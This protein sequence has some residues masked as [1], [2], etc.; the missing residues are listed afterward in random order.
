[1]EIWGLSVSPDLDTLTY[2][3]AG[4]LDVARGWGLAGE[5]FRCLEAMVDLGGE[6]W[7]NL[8][9]R[10]LATHLVRTRLLRDGHAPL[11]GDRRASPAGSGS[12]RASC[13]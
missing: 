4:R 7:F 9:D 13:R 5:T 10:D 12:G 8:G 2:A 6:T 1:M 3:L 11:R